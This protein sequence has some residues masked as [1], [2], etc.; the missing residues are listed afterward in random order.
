MSSDQVSFNFCAVKIWSYWIL[1]KFWNEKLSFR[2]SYKISSSAE[3]TRII[4]KADEF[5]CP[6]GIADSEDYCFDL[7]ELKYGV[8]YTADVSAWNLKKRIYRRWQRLSQQMLIRMDTNTNM[9][10]IKKSFQIVYKLKSGEWT[11]SGSPLFF[12]LVEAG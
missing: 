9:Q 11:T 8:Q 2:L 7:S 3:W 4:K 1:K 10:L 12:I 5:T 6:E